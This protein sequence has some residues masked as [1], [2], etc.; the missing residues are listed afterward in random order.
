MGSGGGSSTVV[1]VNMSEFEPF[2]PSVFQGP[3][4]AQ[5]AIQNEQTLEAKYPWIT[6]VA[7]RMT[8]AVSPNFPGATAGPGFPTA[9]S[10][11]IT[12]P[13]SPPPTPQQVQQFSPNP[14]PPFSPSFSPGTASS[15]PQSLVSLQS[16]LS[17]LN[18]SP[19]QSNL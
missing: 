16:I 15:G 14:Q 1:P 2:A 10:T 7:G 18:P 17:A 5:S 3:Y 4:G 19:G 6:P 9:I 11:G 8:G 12:S 13:N